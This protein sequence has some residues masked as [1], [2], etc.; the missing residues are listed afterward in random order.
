MSVGSGKR[1]VAVIAPQRSGTSAITRGLQTLGVKLGD[2]Y[3][4]DFKDNDNE[5]GYFEDLEISNIDIAMLN[6]IGYTW[7]NPVLPEFDENTR[8][9]LSAFYPIAADII[10]RRLEKWDIFGFKDPNFSKLL[11]F[12]QEVFK[13]SGASNVSYIIAC[14]N[15]LNVAASM[16]KRDGFDIIK[17]FYIWLCATMSSLIYTKGYNRIVVDYDELMKNPEKQLRRMAEQLSLK[18]DAGDVSFKEYK[19]SFLSDSLRHNNFSME[20]LEDG[21]I[22]REI[23]PKI[24]ELYILLRGITAG[25]V[26]IDDLEVSVKINKIYSWMRELRSTLLYMQAQSDAL[27]FLKKQINEK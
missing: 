11:P 27:Y 16:Q 2:Y 5:K 12:W 15:P 24:L 4:K 1:I 14:R 7:D 8:E 9:V 18:L 17:G 3:G 22:K 6:S 21:I 23:P 25:K 19:D 10:K 20:D 13:E 26:G